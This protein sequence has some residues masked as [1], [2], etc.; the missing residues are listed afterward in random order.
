MKPRIGPP[1]DLMVLLVWLTLFL[2]GIG[3]VANVAF[4]VSNWLAGLR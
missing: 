3:L 1:T 4:Y 2:A